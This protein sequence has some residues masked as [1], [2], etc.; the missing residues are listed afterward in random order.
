MS[1]NWKEVVRLRFT[2]DRFRD[3]A[4]DLGA[5]SELSQ[6]QKIVAETAKALWRA[7]N[8]GRERLP[9]H[10]EER[11]RLCLRKIEDGSAAAPLEVFIEDQEQGSL[12]EPEPVEANE[13]VALAYEVF[14]A[15]EKNIMLPERFPRSLVTEY[16]KLGQTLAETEEIE[17]FPPER[18]PARL[19]V[20]SRARL[21]EYSHEEH[22]A[23]VDV[24]GHVLEADV[25]RQR[26]QLWLDDTM[27]VTVSF[28]TAQEDE[29]TTALKEHERVSLHVRG[30]G[31][32][33]AIGALLRITRIDEMALKLAKELKF[34]FGARRIEDILR[35]LSDQVPETDWS[36]LPAD[37]TD[38]LDHYLY[39][40]PSK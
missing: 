19:T 11:T 18:E 20:V 1:G 6:F 2:G 14:E 38:D 4:L 28:T 13:A 35:E 9:W 33:S 15:L 3:H 27:Q 24:T 25:K 21:M 39:G 12:F 32:Y 29:V 16:T 36:S 7:A 31:K 26:F 8:P 40:T 23:Q 22:E 17:I 37:L 10:F 30:R 5:L 34:D